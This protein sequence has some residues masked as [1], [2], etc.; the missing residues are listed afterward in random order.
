M[1][2]FKWLLIGVLVTAALV[3]ITGNRIILWIHVGIATTYALL[4]AKVIFTGLWAEAK[5]EVEELKKIAIN[6]SSE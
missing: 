4:A 3:I 6:E 1:K 2:L 5:R